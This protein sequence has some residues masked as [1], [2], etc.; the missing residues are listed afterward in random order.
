[1]THAHHDY[2]PPADP[3]VAAKLRAW[4]DLK[5]GIIVHF[6]LYSELGCVESWGLC[7]EPWVKVPNDDHAA[8]AREYRAAQ[9][10]FRPAK[11]DAARWAQAF[12]DAGAGYVIFTAKH[13]DGF[14]LY[15]SKLTD[16][17]VT[18]PGGPF[19]GDP[20]ADVFRT[21]ADACRA[22]GL[23]I[24]AYFSK[25]DWNAPGFWCGE[26]A[27]VDRNPTYDITAHP[28][29]WQEFVRFTHGQVDE[30]MS[31]Y[32]PI[33]MLWLDGCWVRPKHTIDDRVREFCTYPHDMD[34][35]MAEIA[36]RARA[37]Q[38]GMLV[39]DRWVP[40]EFENYL[41]PEQ[42]VPPEPVPVPWESCI[43]IGRDWGWVAGDEPKPA[44]DLVALLV[45]IVAKGGNLLLGIG[46]RGDG[47][48]E[49]VVLERLAEI[50]AWMRANRAAI[51]GSRPHAPYDRNQVAY[52]R[53]ADGATYAI[54]I[55]QETQAEAP[56]ILDVEGDFPEG[57]RATLLEGGVPL[58]ATPIP[59]GLRV[60]LPDDVRQRVLQA[61]PAIR[62]SAAPAP[63]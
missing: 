25:P 14:C 39:V 30:L 57:T 2:V 23:W 34:I 55:P 16:F 10:R 1:V 17:K 38:P 32:G 51:V 63:D 15:D 42:R 9:A 20:R 5:F 54:W 31:D 6:G 29:R 7:P 58:A 13:H 53:G 46:P 49:P 59:G 26:R 45:R 50:G 61:T 60:R 3:A 19:A 41:T 28:E 36:A 33:D 48:L 43:T 56:A 47:E 11:L 35:R 27:P 37:R 40:G 52:T 44:R 22:Q 24:G 18:A 62:L 12:R 4:Q 21:V 8:F